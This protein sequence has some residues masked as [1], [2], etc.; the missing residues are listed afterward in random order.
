MVVLYY[1]TKWE[2]FSQRHATLLWIKSHFNLAFELQNSSAQ[3]GEL[4]DL[5]VL[6][7]EM[8]WALYSRALEN[9][10]SNVMP[11]ATCAKDVI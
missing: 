1:Y 6:F 7:G 5:I 2:F 9:N 8:T 11:T 4:L 10:V 3:Q